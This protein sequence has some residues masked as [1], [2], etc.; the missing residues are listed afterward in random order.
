MGGL[1]VLIA[2]L[3]CGG[4]FAGPPAATSPKAAEVAAQDYYAACMDAAAIARLGT[5]PLAAELQRIAALQNSRQ[6]AHP[7]ADLHSVG[8]AALFALGA[9]AGTAP[10]TPA[11]NAANLAH[12]TAL[13]ELLGDTPAVAAEEARAALQV[14]A[15][16]AQARLHNRG[17]RQ[18]LTPAALARLV[19]NFDWQGY[20]N[21][22]GH[23]PKA[24]RGN[25]AYLKALNG[26]LLTVELARWKSYLR[27]LWLYTGAPLLPQAFRR[28]HAALAARPLPRS[29]AALCQAQVH[30]FTPRQ[31]LAARVTRGTYFADTMR[32][33]AARVL[34]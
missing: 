30:A 33:R 18:P 27:W 8:V 20:F 13:F 6:L 31:L 23:A 29:R 34:Q 4:Q 24:M 26:R 25:P 7:I 11:D 28:E 10:A 32:L 16:L 12:V 22:L 1:W 17:A 2:I 19:P 15:S 21:A 14:G 5:E 9:G 3:V